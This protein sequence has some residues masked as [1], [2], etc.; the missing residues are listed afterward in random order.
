MS[1]YLGRLAAG[2]SAAGIRTPVEVMQSRGSE[3]MDPAHLW[4]KFRGSGHLL[5][6][7]RQ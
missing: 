4:R 3:A 2:L 6:L 7:L 1:G 5:R